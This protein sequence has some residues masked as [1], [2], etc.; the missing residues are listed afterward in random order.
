[1][2]TSE[3]LQETPRNALAYMFVMAANIRQSNGLWQ[4]IHNAVRGIGP[5]YVDLTDQVCQDCCQK[6]RN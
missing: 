5:F 6:G 4:C 1:M 2:R 3:P